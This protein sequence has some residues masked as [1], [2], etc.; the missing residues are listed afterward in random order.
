MEVKHWSGRGASRCSPVPVLL[1]VHCASIVSA[2]FHGSFL[3]LQTPVAL[4]SLVDEHRQWFKSNLGLPGCPQ[5][6]R[7]SSF[8]AFALLPS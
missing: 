6:E 5:T 1:P 2:P 8:C 7:A 3:L 4:V